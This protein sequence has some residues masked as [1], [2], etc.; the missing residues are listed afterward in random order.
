MITGALRAIVR[1]RSMVRALVGFCLFAAAEFGT[2]VAILVYA[3]VQGGTVEAGLIGLVILVPPVVVA[4]L[5]SSLG[6][7]IRRDRALGL[8]YVAQA[9]TCIATGVV[10]AMDAPSLVVYAMA[11]L[12]ACAFTLTRPVHLAI[13]PDLA[14]M[15]EELIAG[16]VA[17]TTLEQLGYFLGPI[18]SAAMIAIGGPGLV[19]GVMGVTL[20]GSAALTISTPKALRAPRAGPHEH[21]ATQSILSA[22]HDGVTELRRNPGARSLVLLAGGTGWCSG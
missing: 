10:L 6:D 21:D 16:N 11:L 13:L 22:T 17:S 18:L 4:P 5:A 19:F 2:W 12:A 1:N 9:V 20:L 3:F 8:G 7:R 14:E 15:P